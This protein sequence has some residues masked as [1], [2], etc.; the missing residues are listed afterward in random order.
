LKMHTQETSKR[1]FKCLYLMTIVN[2]IYFLIN[3]D[4][5]LM[6]YVIS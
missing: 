3:I 6:V 4:E 2:S 1:K 5:T